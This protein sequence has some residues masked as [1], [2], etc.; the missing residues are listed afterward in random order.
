MSTQGRH[1]HRPTVAVVARIVDVLHSGGDINSA[2]NMCRVIRFDNIF[3]PVAQPAVPQQETE[4]AIREVYLM[5]FLDPVR[6]E[7][8][9]GAVLLAM[10]QRS[11]HPNALIERRIDLSV[12]K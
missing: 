7:G 8:N 3:P 11:V 5:I 4:T 10:P 1:H 12:G 2:P 9:T 6:H